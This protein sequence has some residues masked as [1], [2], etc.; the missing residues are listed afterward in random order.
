MRVAARPPGP[1]PV[2]KRES[3]SLGQG[4]GTSLRADATAQEAAAAEAASGKRQAAVAAASGGS[5]GALLLNTSRRA[6]R[7]GVRV[8]EEG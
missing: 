4:G 1:R 8:C 3:L 6:A 2:S 7:F 5:G